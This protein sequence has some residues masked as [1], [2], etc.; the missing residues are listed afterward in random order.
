MDWSR[1]SDNDFEHYK[2][3]LDSLLDPIIDELI[4]CDNFECN[5]HSDLILGF[6]DRIIDAMNA[7]AD[8]TIPK[9]K[10]SC[11][12]RGLPGW[13]EYVSC[14]FVIYSFRV[15][16]LLTPFRNKILNL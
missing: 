16:P 10:V 4:T 1:P 13:K 15:S 2:F 14:N 9:I 5:Y 8:L 12:N 3:L 7:A 11:K 6:F